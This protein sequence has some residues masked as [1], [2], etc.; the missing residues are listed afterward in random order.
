MLKMPLLI[1]VGHETVI[2]VH[3]NT[4]QTLRTEAIKR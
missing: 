2:D 1:N 4:I 3:G